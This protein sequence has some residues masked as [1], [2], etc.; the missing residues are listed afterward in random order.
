[1]AEEPPLPLRRWLPLRLC[2]CTRMAEI[3]RPATGGAL[4][5]RAGRCSTPP[6]L[7][8]APVGPTHSSAA[9]FCAPRTRWRKAESRTSHRRRD[10]ASFAFLHLL[11]SIFGVTGDETVDL[12]GVE[13]TQL[14]SHS[15]A[16]QHAM[17]DPQ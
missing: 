4:K 17:P 10:A 16:A 9:V 1:M 13:L 14:E 7:G 11:S 2:G 6:F 5:P 12:Y 15:R 8:A 3:T